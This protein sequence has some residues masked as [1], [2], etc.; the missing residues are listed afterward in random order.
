MV[1]VVVVEDYV[2]VV[3]VVAESSD[4]PQDFGFVDSGSG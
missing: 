4:F 1:L 3:E 2:E